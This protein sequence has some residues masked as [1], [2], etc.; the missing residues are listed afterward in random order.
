MYQ[1]RWKR[2]I[3]TRA[4]RTISKYHKK[5]LRKNYTR[6]SNTNTKDNYSEVLPNRQ[7]NTEDQTIEK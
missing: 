4:F 3:C 2:I 1:I 5:F 7:L 6:A